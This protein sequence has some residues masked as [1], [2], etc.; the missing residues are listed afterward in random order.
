MKLQK[1]AGATSEIWQ[2]F[3][4]NSAL[5]TGAGL[6][7]LVFNTSGLTAYYHRDTDTTA[8]AVTLATMTVGT[9]TSSGFKEIDATN[10]PGWYQ[11]CPPNA[12]IA[13]GAKSCGFHLQG[14]ANMAP[15]PIEVQLVAVNPDDAVRY[16]MTALPNVAA[17]GA[18]GLY[19]RGTGAGQ[20]NQPANGMID[21]NVV[22]W[23][24]T[25][26]STP[27]V[28]GVPNVNAKTWNDLATVALPLIPT[29]AGRTLD[30]SATGE[31]GVDWANI[32]APTTVNNLSGTTVK[33]ATDVATAVAVVQS[34][35]DDIQ[36]RLPAA[37]VGGRMDS[38]IG[39]VVAG[40]IAAA[41][42]AAGALDAVW[43]TAAR[44]LTAGTN[45][46][47]AKG[48]GVTGFN[49]LSEANVRTAVGLASSNLDTQL[50]AIQSDT[51]NLQTRLP[52]ALVSG[53]MAS[54]A[55][56]VDDKTGYAVGVGGIAATAF[57]A[58]A[59]D[60]AALATDAVSEIADGVLAANVE[61]TVTVVQSLRLQN[62]ASGAKLSGAATAT[63]AIRDL[64]DTKDR[65]T[66]TVDANGNRTAVT[67]DLS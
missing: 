11:F 65:I 9:F 7:G 27:T 34:D 5:T 57:A 53:R 56:V 64:D 3:I 54:V 29:T 37:L 6:T 20:I 8:T 19:T 33:T 40:V 55:Q 32:G 26:V 59:I 22:R 43:S 2:V 62:A 12:A 45:I 18:G 24:G 67:R 51:D 30:V 52:A 42:F 63:V 15:L 16:G 14:A 47:L 39:A 21:G 38:S 23:L 25:A 35:T 31:A 49:D 60:A 28:A 17:E 44:L 50:A 41:S 46:V 13:A 1:L 58:G 48:V 61:G 66:A 10:M 4:Q 36:S